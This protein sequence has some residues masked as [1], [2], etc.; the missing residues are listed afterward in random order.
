MANFDHFFLWL[1]GGQVEG[2]ASNRGC[3]CPLIPP[4]CMPPLPL[5][6]KGA[7]FQYVIFQTIL[8]EKLNKVAYK[9]IKY[10]L[11]TLLQVPSKNLNQRMRFH[12]GS[13]SL[14]PETW[15]IS[16]RLFLLQWLINFVFLA[17]CSKLTS[18]HIT[19]WVTPNATHVQWHNP[20]FLGGGA[21]F[22]GQSASLSRGK[23]SQ[24]TEK[25][26]FCIFF[27][28]GG[29]TWLGSLLYH[30]SLCGF[31]NIQHVL[32][33]E[34]IVQILLATKT[35]HMHEYLRWLLSYNTQYAEKDLIL[36]FN[37]FGLHQNP[38]TSLHTNTCTRAPNRK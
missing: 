7:A 12:N 37:F 33:V 30:Y 14:M 11:N 27:W 20:F 3:K 10:K 17:P 29:G 19:V 15:S 34:E 28:G 5:R 35:A 22:E 1:G 36:Y 4:W 9:L 23:V 24:L 21:L 38:A 31:L 16:I 18:C 6:E 13:C 26:W 8:K 2:R 32:D 25:S